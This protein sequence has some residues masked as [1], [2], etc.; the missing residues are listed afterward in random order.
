MLQ[1]VRFDP[2]IESQDSLVFHTVHIFNFGGL[3][4]I[5]CTRKNAEFVL[6]Q[7]LPFISKPKT[8]LQNVNIIIC[9]GIFWDSIKLKID[10]LQHITTDI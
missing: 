8:K 9:K 10:F 2:I 1:K 5:R 3:S 4:E 7:S 6:Y